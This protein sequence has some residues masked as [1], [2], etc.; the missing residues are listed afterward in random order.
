MANQRMLILPS[1][2]L[3]CISRVHFTHDITCRTG[4]VNII[5]ELL[6]EERDFIDQLDCIG[7]INYFLVIWVIV[8]AGSG[9]DSQILVSKHYEWAHF[10]GGCQ[11]W[12]LFTGQHKPHCTSCAENIRMREQHVWKETDIPSYIGSSS[13]LSNTYSVAYVT[14]I[15]HTQRFVYTADTTDVC[16]ERRGHL[17]LA[18]I[19]SICLFC[20]SDW[21]CA[22]CSCK[23]RCRKPS[24]A[25]MMLMCLFCCRNWRSITC[26]MWCEYANPRTRR[27]S[28]NTK[29]YQC[30]I[31][32]TTTERPHQP[33]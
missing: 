21:R 33:R 15:L 23:E 6:T 12:V 10:Y 2:Y 11:V 14:S 8:I 31:L 22:R 13:E 30:S 4:T 16:K 9:G 20:C 25:E 26:A 3:M 17:L 1:I 29:E 24:P 27:R 28:W 19:I 32:L 5:F 7:V 18:E